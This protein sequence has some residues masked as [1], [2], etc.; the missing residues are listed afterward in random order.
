MAELS[1]KDLDKLFQTGSEQYDF[2]YN[3]EAWGQMEDLLDF[4]DHR[5]RVIWWLLGG[6]IIISGVF[7]TLYISNR[8]S[9]YN[10]NEEVIPTEELDVIIDNKKETALNSGKGINEKGQKPK[11]EPFN[12]EGKTL[13]LR[14]PINYHI[15]DKIA[16][17][18]RDIPRENANISSTEIIS[19]I[20]IETTQFE[21]LLNNQNVQSEEMSGDERN[22]ENKEFEITSISASEIFDVTPIISHQREEVKLIGVLPFTLLETDT[23]FTKEM[24]L[25]QPALKEWPDENNNLIKSK[26]FLVGLVIATELTSSGIDDF[27]KLSWKIGSEFEYRYNDRYSA[28]VGVNFIRKNYNVGEGEYIPPIGF[29][30]RGIAPQSVS[31]TNNVI[32]VPLMLGYY[33]K[34]YNE[35][36]FFVNLGLN[37]YFMIR[38]RYEYFY[39]LPDTDLV[40]EWGTANENKHWFGIGQFSLG[41][42][43]RINNK[44]IAKF[45]PY[46]Q[47][48]LTGLGH[49]NVRLWSIGVNFSVNF[50]LK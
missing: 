42:T 48:P 37:S 17:I 4:D 2:E 22:I 43:K 25:V 27:S 44:M 45:S 5:R 15:K 36:G 20:G 34:K 35:N 32:E 47:I 29:W 26:N 38:E 50:E 41:Y 30:T 40:R 7:F 18:Q 39:E 9:I 12:E 8:A 11:N 46:V 10:H 14:E 6:L 16:D 1:K 49:G 23:Y 33:Q 31:G 13:W 21:L 3:E 19:N 28:G 24:T